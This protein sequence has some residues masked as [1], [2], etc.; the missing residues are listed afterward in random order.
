MLTQCSLRGLSQHDGV[1]DRNSVFYA[2][3]PYPSA[4]SKI[5][6]VCWFVRLTKDE[7][8]TG[9]TS[10]YL[11]SGVTN[12]DD[13]HCGSRDEWQIHKEGARPETRSLIR[14]SH[15]AL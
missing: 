6:G 8:E 1:R 15:S 14:D 9:D 13:G 12:W 10:Y 5:D 7:T 4:G 2:T 11:P 3:V